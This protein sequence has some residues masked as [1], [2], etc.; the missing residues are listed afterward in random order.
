[1]SFS[2][3]SPDTHHSRTAASLSS[4]WADRLSEAHSVVSSAQLRRRQRLVTAKEEGAEQRAGAV[5]GAESRHYH[6]IIIKSARAQ[7]REAQGL[8]L[9]PAIVVNIQS[10]IKSISFKMRKCNL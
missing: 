7:E 3:Q 4:F 8:Q 9:T 1:M 5:R 6:V 2:Q 10:Q